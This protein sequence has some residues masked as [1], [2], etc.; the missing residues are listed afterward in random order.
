MQPSSPDAPPSGGTP[1]PDVGSSH[2]NATQFPAYA[3]VGGA[4]VLLGLAIAARALGRRYP[5]LGRHVLRGVGVAVLLALAGGGAWYVLGSDHHENLSSDCSVNGFGF[6]TCSFTNK[7][8]LDASV[9]GS[10]VVRNLRSGKSARS[11]EFCSGVIERRTTKSVDFRVD[12]R[13]HCDGDPGERSDNIC[14]L[15]FEPAGG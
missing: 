11:S 3:I 8:V 10:V 6:G 12:I 4:G 13:S 14:S 7:G 2:S 1:S 9:C 15:N 5:R